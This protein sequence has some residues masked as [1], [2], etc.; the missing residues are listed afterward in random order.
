MELALRSQAVSELVTVDNHP[1]RIEDLRL[2]KGRVEGRVVDGLG[3]IARVQMS[4]DGGPWREV[5][6]TDTLF[7]GPDERFQAEPG[8]AEGPHI[9]AVRAF[10]AAGNQANREI[11]VGS[12]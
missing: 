5:Y 11:S 3:P 9:I 12:R 6:P 7:D 4:I 10:D 8:L 2:K 1:P